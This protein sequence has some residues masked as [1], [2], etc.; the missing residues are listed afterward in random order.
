MRGGFLPVAALACCAWAAPSNAE[1]LSL[2]SALAIA[3]DTNPQL[4]QARAQLRATDENVAE[5]DANWRPQIQATGTYGY[6]HG[7]EQGL[8]S[9]F[10]THPLSAQISAT[11]NIFR[12]G[13]NFAEFARAKAQVSSAR[14]QLSDAERTVLLNAVTAYV[15]VVRDEAVVGMNRQNV[16]SLEDELSAVQTQR[17]AGVVTKTDVAESQARLSR[18]KADLAAAERQLATSRAAFQNVIGQPAPTLDPS[19]ALPALPASLD[20]AETAAG[21]DSPKVQQARADLKAADYA[22]ND[23]IG[24]LLPQV[25]VTGQYQYLKDQAAPNLLYVNPA[26]KM[27]SVMGQITIPIY[28]GGAEDAQVR[29]AKELRGGAQM[30]LQTAQR[31][32]LQDVDNAWQGWLAAQSQIAANETQVKADGF[33]VYGVTQE[34]QAGERSVLDVLNARQELLAAQVALATARHDRI[35][36]A[37]QVL[38]AIGRLSA[39]GLKLPVKPYDPLV[40]YN[41]DAGAWI[42]LGD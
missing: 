2:Q 4:G 38:W 21:V 15:D 6:L 23:A 1:V 36:A 16:K 10:N 17:A 9:P 30:A 11:E 14:A 33:A 8:P 25:G 28:Q 18:S 19:P 32:V 34:Q 22:V 24:A 7:V 13:R 37:Y 41:K 40:H 27:L 39:Q 42:G 20:T 12:G 31:T 3:Y 29:Q 26:Q 35:V 5:A